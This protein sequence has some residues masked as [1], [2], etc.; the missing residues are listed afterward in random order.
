MKT[1]SKLRYPSKISLSKDLPGDVSEE[2]GRSCEQIDALCAGNLE[3]VKE[4]KDIAVIKQL[5]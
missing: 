3:I 1:G 5:I 2:I 4:R